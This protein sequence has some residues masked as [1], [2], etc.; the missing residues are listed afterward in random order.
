[1]RRGIAACN[2]EIIICRDADTFT[3]SNN[4]LSS[5]VNYMAATKKEFVI[6][7]IAIDHKKEF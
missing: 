7:P 2:S 6:C 5:I 1:M 4:W 3:V